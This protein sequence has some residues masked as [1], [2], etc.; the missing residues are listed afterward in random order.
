M[1]ANLMHVLRTCKDRHALCRAFAA[2]DPITQDFGA[3]LGADFGDDSLQVTS[4]AP[5]FGF[6]LD[7]WITAPS[8]I[9]LTTAD[10]L[11][12]VFVSNR[13]RKSIRADPVALSC[14]AM[15]D[16]FQFRDLCMGGHGSATSGCCCDL[17]LK[18]VCVLQLDES[19][20]VQC[21]QAPPPLHSSPSQQGASLPS[22][23]GTGLVPTQ[24]KSSQALS[25]LPSGG[26]PAM[27]PASRTP[28]QPAFSLPSS[29][30]PATQPASGN[31]SQP[32]FSLPSD[33]GSARPAAGRRISPLAPSQRSGDAAAQSLPPSHPSQRPGRVP[34]SGGSTAP[35][36]SGE[37][38]LQ[39][40]SLPTPAARQA[41][42]PAPGG[43]S[44]AGGGSSGA[45]LRSSVQ[46]AAAASAVADLS[47]AD[48]DAGLGQV[49]TRPGAV[50]QAP[51]PAAMLTPDPAAGAMPR[52]AQ[53]SQ[54][55]CNPAAQQQQRSPAGAGGG[56]ELQ[57]GSSGDGSGGRQGVFQRFTS[58]FSRR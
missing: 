5:A 12:H 30:D 50:E 36:N 55:L 25:S 15:L 20:P 39:T 32:P 52:A 10:L 8:Y 13:V 37:P 11:L 44:S 17:T 23:N 46:H 57:P 54:Q 29:G 7:N 27:Q 43:G 47:P 9:C 26:S 56:R 33:G 24:G 28:N 58:M 38:S 40:V 41:C 14:D 21:G 53:P 31:P 3:S 4:V 35:R 34:C 19:Q 22:S 48:A 16:M 45:A 49:L 51:R 42:N 2:P 6:H 1:T 18:H